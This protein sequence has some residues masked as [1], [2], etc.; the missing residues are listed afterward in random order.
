MLLFLPTVNLMRHLRKCTHQ[1]LSLILSQSSILQP[2]L[3]SCIDSGWIFKTSNDL[4][5]MYTWYETVFESCESLQVF[6]KFSTKLNLFGIDLLY[7]HPVLYTSHGLQVTKSENRRLLWNT[8]LYMSAILSCSASRGRLRRIFII[9]CAQRFD[10]PT[11]IYSTVH[12]HRYHGTKRLSA[13]QKIPI[14]II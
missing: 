7:K 3:R 9:V 14:W 5:Y 12:Q 13:I 2:R 10:S 8:E 1:K 4:H 11:A 6:P